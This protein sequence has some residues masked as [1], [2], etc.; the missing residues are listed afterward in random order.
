MFVAYFGD[1]VIAGQ[2]PEHVL[3]FLEESLILALDLSQE[4][5]P[6]GDPRSLSSESGYLFFV[7]LKMVGVR[8]VLIR[9]LMDN[10]DHNVKDVSQIIDEF[11]N[12]SVHSLLECV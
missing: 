3:Q 10:M 2:H 5:N 6:H 9:V 4:V 8:V 11:L 7:E 1:G 12:R